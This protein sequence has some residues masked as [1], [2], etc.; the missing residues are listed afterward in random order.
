MILRFF[1]SDDTV[2]A[3][4]MQGFLHK[5]GLPSDFFIRSRTIQICP[6]SSPV[7]GP[8][9]QKGYIEYG[10]LKIPVFI[11]PKDIS[12][13]GTPLALYHGDGEKYP[14]ITKNADQISVGFDFFYHR[15]ILL[16]GEH[17]RIWGRE[18]TTERCS[19]LKQSYIDRFDAL[20]FELI[21]DVC[22]NE[23]LFVIHKAFWPEAKPMAVCLTHD[24]DEMKKTYQWITY[25]LKM[26]KML[27][28]S[29]FVNQ[30]KSFIKK[31]Q[32]QEPYWT[33]DTITGM[34]KEVHAVSS[35]YFL[36]ETSRVRFFDRR[37]WRHLGRRYNWNDP[38][39][40]RLIR[41]LEND[42]WEVGLHGSFDS[43]NSQEKIHEEKKSLERIIKMPLAG[44]RQHNLNLA[45][46]DTWLIH[47]KEQFLYDTTLGSNRC[48]GFRWGTSFP[49]RPISL[50]E[51][52]AVNV[53]QLPLIIEDI[54]FFRNPDPWA[55]FLLLF[56]ETM[57]YNG[58]LT[59]LWHPAVLNSLEFPSW[60]GTYKKILDY[61]SGKNAWISSGRE[62]A[63]W[64]HKREEVNYEWEL[65]G[66]E[67]IITI[68]GDAPAG[69]C[70]TVYYPRNK[71]VV[72]VKN[73]KLAVTGDNSCQIGI[74]PGRVQNKKIIV[75]ITGR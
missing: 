42:G 74:M 38:D 69:F 54:P 51:R 66:N 65:S 37:T 22:Q 63:G 32:G 43:F 13:C 75:Y 20:I 58:N 5:F 53:L 7:P 56:N 16:S 49:F 46:P 25:P 26:L 45:I 44:T 36:W 40:A 27:D 34:E 14:C 59:L 9:T 48:T 2:S 18:W 10:S 19:L 57:V 3:L 64:W 55:D 29:G 30:V 71:R 4:G 61:C 33:F 24:V 41:S 17:E 62:I 52:R 72:S 15:G 39:I 47:E 50:S 6:E 68:T 23:G 35:F 8:P 28:Y 12:G 31:I 67:I 21:K 73:A 11:E 60:S 70:L 1:S